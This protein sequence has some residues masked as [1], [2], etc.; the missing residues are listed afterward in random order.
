MRGKE[1]THE[2]AI[3]CLHMIE[4]H[5]GI[6]ED[7]LALHLRWGL[8]KTIKVLRCLMRKNLV[9]TISSPK[10]YRIK[11]MENLKM[12]KKDKECMERFKAESGSCL[13]W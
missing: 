3:A 2:D 4:L 6:T 11:A 9:R 5:D 7:T 12:S 10:Y 1:V 13:W 8:G